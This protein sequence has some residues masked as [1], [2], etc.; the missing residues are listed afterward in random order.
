MK[1]TRQARRRTPTAYTYIAPV[2]ARAI[3]WGVRKWLLLLAACGGG[4]ADDGLGSGSDPGS[5]CSAIPADESGSGTYYDADGTG[6]C[7]FDASPNDLIVAAMNHAD[8]GVAD[9][10]G[11]C[12]QVSGPNGTATVRVV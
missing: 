12:L 3:R 7:G 6:N 8:Y 2:H 11:A 5:S 1:I 4:T 10:C 9:W